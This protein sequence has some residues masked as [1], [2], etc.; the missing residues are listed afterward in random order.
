MPTYKIEQ[1]KL[2]GL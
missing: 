1:W 2:E